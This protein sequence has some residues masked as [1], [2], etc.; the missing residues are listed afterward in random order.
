MEKQI[1]APED[2][3]VETPITVRW[4]DMDAIG[5]V[6]NARYLTYCEMS[7][8]DWFGKVA[9]G[10]TLADAPVFPVLARTE[11]DFLRSIVY[12]A[13]I[14]VLVRAVHAGR[15]SIV[16]EYLIRDAQTG[17][18]YALAKGTLVFIDR[19]THRAHAIPEDIR[20]KMRELDGV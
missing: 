4:S 9:E 13:D 11:C 5:H 17:V 2:F 18:N 16:L 19:E 12:P 10:Q 7:N 6:N 8:F 14:K 20:E 15:S 1:P 3:K